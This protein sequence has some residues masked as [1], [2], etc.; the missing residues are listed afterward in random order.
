MVNENKMATQP[1]G[2]S[3][4]WLRDGAFEM[5][6]A[7]AILN[8]NGSAGKVADCG[9]LEWQRLPL[10]GVAPMKGTSCKNV[11]L[12]DHALQINEIVFV[13][14]HQKVIR[15]IIGILELQWEGIPDLGVPHIPASRPRGERQLIKIG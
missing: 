6:L 5:D 8:L 12:R 4:A 15:Q 14:N 11:H 10:A 1:S 7:E 13:F 3:L 9:D 2:D